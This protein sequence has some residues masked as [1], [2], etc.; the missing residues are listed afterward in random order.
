MVLPN[1]PRSWIGKAHIVGATIE[2]S[3]SA[4]AP[5]EQEW[6]LISGAPASCTQ[7]GLFHL[8]Q[9][10][11]PADLVVSGPNFGRNATTIYNLSSGTV[12]GALEAALCKKK[13]IALSF[14]SK[15]VQPLNTIEA[16]SRISVKL[17][18]NL[19]HNWGSGVE[20]Y[21]INVPMAVDVE[22]HQ[23]LYTEALR[24]RWSSGSLYQERLTNACHEEVESK[25]H[26]EVMTNGHTEV[27]TNGYRHEDSP[28][29][30]KAGGH[31]DSSKELAV[32]RTRFFKWAPELSDITRCV[33][34]SPRGTDAWALE[35][36]F[37]RYERCCF[38]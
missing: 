16:A 22:E 23:I 17:I 15:G 7:L 2:C 30:E 35:N 36:R 34:E 11:L 3:Y 26:T 24:S 14:A 8:F 27:M 19:Y 32:S 28:N 33:N 38:S 29:L 10:L 37:I 5:G 31:R 20:L 25:G 18:E 6:V 21:N 12:G 13:A 4:P 1:I 9:D